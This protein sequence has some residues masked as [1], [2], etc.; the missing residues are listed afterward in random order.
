MSKNTLK[1]AEKHE[2][3]PF[4]ESLKI[5]IVTK[6]NVVVARD[7]AVVNVVSGEVSNDTLLMG[8]R[9][10]VDGDEFVKIYTGYLRDLF[11][12][13]K[14]TQKVF[15]YLLSKMDFTDKVHLIPSE[16]QSFCGYTSHR[17]IFEGLNELCEKG[18]IAKTIWSNVYWINPKFFYKGD[19]LVVM[20]EYHR[21][22]REKLDPNQTKLFNENA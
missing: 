8:R 7:E 21:I 3:N 22:R 12:L 18:I 1:K 19:R 13:E 17:P 2:T 11:D 4:V 5:P 15:S 14:S 9:R 10:Y 6:A 20:H 16:I